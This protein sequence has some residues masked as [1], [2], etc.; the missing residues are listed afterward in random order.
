[1]DNHFYSVPHRLVRKQVEVRLSASTVEVLYDG[2][3]VAAHPRSRRAGR[4]T[5]DPAHRPKAHREHLAWPPSRLIRWAEK[6]GPQTAV[7]VT[8]ILESKP[9]PEQGYRPCLGLLRLGDRYSPER[10]EA[11]C[12]RALMIGGASYRSIKSILEHDLD[13]LPLEEQAT[14]DL[15]QEHENVR[16]ADYYSTW[17]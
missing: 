7:V 2:K 13:R 15:P 14:L 17:N 4:F 12:H 5:T 8:R 6:T 11:A 10:L 16:G 9:H 1:M 3:R